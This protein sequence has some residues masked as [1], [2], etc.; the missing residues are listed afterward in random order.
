M[1]HEALRVGMFW[2]GL[3]IAAVPM[4]LGLAVGVFV[5]RRYW[6]SRASRPSDA[7]RD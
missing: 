1:E 7:G 4:L 5:L 6:M 2:G 3:V